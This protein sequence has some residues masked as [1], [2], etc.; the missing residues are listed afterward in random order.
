MDHRVRDDLTQHLF[1]DF[2]VRPGAGAD[3]ERGRAQVLGYGLDGLIY[4]LGHV[5]VA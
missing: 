3:H 4:G 1:G 5:A 2:R